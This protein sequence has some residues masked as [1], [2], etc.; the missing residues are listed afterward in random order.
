MEIFLLKL[1]YLKLTCSFLNP[2]HIRQKKVYLRN[3]SCFWLQFDKAVG[4]KLLDKVSACSWQ[5]GCTF[6]FFLYAVLVL[7][8]TAI[9][10]VPILSHTLRIAVSFKM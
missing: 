4:S 7:M 10:F 6:N 8:S 1:E 3:L 2:V 5:D 9:H